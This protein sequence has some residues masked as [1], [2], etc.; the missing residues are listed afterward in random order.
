MKILDM[1]SSFFSLNLINSLFCLSIIAF[2]F[3][4]FNLAIF[5]Y[6]F[7]FNKRSI[8]GYRALIEDTRFGVPPF[9]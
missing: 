5:Y 3:F 1:E 2:E 4:I 6:I 9:Y 8:I 7:K